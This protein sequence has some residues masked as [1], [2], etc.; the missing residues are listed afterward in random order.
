[1]IDYS[2]TV[3]HELIALVKS[4]LTAWK[5]GTAEHPAPLKVTDVAAERWDSL[6]ERGDTCVSIDNLEEQGRNL[7][8]R[9][10]SSTIFSNI[11]YK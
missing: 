6:K 9:L 4:E 11:V 8:V 3:M 5:E 7:K 2:K 10:Q 1:M